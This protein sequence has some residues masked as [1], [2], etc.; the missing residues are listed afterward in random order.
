MQKVKIIIVLFLTLFIVNFVKA[1]DFQAN[2]E[3]RLFVVTAY[4][5][6]KS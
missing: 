1:Y 3:E 4:Y 2:C 6:P 5:S